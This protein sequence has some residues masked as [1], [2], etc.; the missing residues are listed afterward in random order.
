MYIDKRKVSLLKLQIIIFS[1]LFLNPIVF[2]AEEN[3]DY[4]NEMAHLRSD[5]NKINLE[6]FKKL[7]REWTEK[8]LEEALT[9]AIKLNR[10]DEL[11][12]TA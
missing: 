9:W 1:T 6:E 10:Q 7:I 2:S 11:R 12:L 5:E 3:I 8:N 4:P